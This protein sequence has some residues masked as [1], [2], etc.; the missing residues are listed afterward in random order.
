[1]K[2][3]VIGPRKVPEHIGGIE[4]VYTNLYP[5][6]VRLSGEAEVT[7]VTRSTYVE[8]PFDYNGTRVVP[9]ESDYSAGFEN[10]WGTL[11]ALFY[12]KRN[13]KPDIVHLHGIGPGIFAPVAR[14]LGFRVVTTHHSRD[15]DRPKWP[16]YARAVLK[17]GE[18]FTCLFSDRIVC[19]SRAL[20]DDIDTRLPFMRR[21]RHAIPNAVAEPATRLSDNGPLERFG[22]DSGCYL[23]CVGRIEETK[24]FDV[25][26]AAYEK[27]NLAIPLVIVGDPGEDKAYAERLGNSTRD[28]RLVGPV[29]GDDLAL[30]YSHS[31]L[32]IN[33]SRMEGYCLVV[34]EAIMNEC[35][36]LL[37]DISVHREFALNDACYFPLNDVDALTSKLMAP[38]YSGFDSSVGRARL[39]E[40]QWRDAAASYWQLYVELAGLPSS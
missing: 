19:V 28:V 38:D 18:V 36:V 26:V 25:A 4:T 37:S 13:L 21:K 5:E 27:A 2:V 9:L 20:K 39:A 10:F 3:C 33:P 11:K 32:L 24:G 29:T 15:Y 16:W 35:R 1:M 40:W 34:A 22:L 12:A 23:L 6:L 17:I 30:L 31:A 7:L 14:I 8:P